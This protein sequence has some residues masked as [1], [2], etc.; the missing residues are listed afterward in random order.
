MS[1]KI[2]KT[3]YTKNLDG[4]PEKWYLEKIL[5][6]GTCFLRKSKKPKWIDTKRLFKTSGVYE[7]RKDCLNGECSVKV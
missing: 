3:V 1:E 2:N 6:D 7:N 5:G 4:T